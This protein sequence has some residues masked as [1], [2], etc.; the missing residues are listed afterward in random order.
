MPSYCL[1]CRKSTERKNPKVVKTKNRR[2]K[3]SSNC[4]VCGS[5]KSQ[6]IKQQEAS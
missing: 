5:K 1:K 4:A 2:I 3:V 6:F